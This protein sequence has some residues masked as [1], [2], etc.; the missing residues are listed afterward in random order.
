MVPWLLAFLG[1]S[2]DYLPRERHT[3]GLLK[4]ARYWS[5]FANIQP[6]TSKFWAI[7]LFSNL[8]K[9]WVLAKQNGANEYF[10]KFIALE[11]VWQRRPSSK[12]RHAA[13]MAMWIPQQA[14]C[15]GALE[16]RK[17]KY[18]LRLTLFRFLRLYPAPSWGTFPGVDQTP[19]P[20]ERRVRFGCRSAPQ[21]YSGL[22]SI[23][24][25]TGRCLETWKDGKKIIISDSHTCQPSNL[26]NSDKW[27]EH[28]KE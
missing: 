16:A 12:A 4:K 2:E 24:S 17:N 20:A 5:D 23:W 13:C 25:H 18:Y 21:H 7:S 26:R 9:I 11:V 3:S 14:M 19:P 15:Q 22:L 28:F 27:E 6:C 10:P 1:T 8:N